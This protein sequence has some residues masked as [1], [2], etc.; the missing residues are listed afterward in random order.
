VRVLSRRRY[1]RVVVLTISLAAP[2][3]AT[4]ACELFVGTDSFTTGLVDASGSSGTGSPD[5]GSSGM[6]A[7]DTGSAGTGSTDTGSPG[8]GSTGTGEEAAADDGGLSTGDEGVA[9]DEAGNLSREAGGIVDTSDA[10]PQT[11]GGTGQCTVV[12][13]E[14]VCLDCWRTSCCT[15]YMECQASAGCAD[16]EA[17]VAACVDPPCSCTALPAAMEL[18]LNLAYCGVASPASH[19]TVDP[20]GT[21]ACANCEAVGV[22][23][24]CEWDDNCVGS[25]TGCFTD[26]YCAASSCA[27]WCAPI[28]PL[29]DGTTTSC[30][31]NAD[32]AGDYAN[33]AS[34][35]GLKNVCIEYDTFNDQTMCFPQCNRLSADACASFPGTSCTGDFDTAGTPVYACE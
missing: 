24:P 34:Q 3:V 18:Y 15:A 20:D 7:T 32:C 31:S 35:N 14:S 16:M 21:S 1:T 9:K 19:P 17:C 30:S 28:D 25:H 23:D 26:G 12:S 2:L 13:G 6:G 11:G 5:T 27:A 33:G 8:T 4:S 29:G 22:G 10:G